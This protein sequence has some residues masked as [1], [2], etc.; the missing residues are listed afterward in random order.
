MTPATAPAVDALLKHV[1]A[2]NPMVS[3]ARVPGVSCSVSCCVGP[4]G[5]GTPGSERAFSIIRVTHFVEDSVL[6]ALILE[7]AFINSVLVGLGLLKP[8]FECVGRGRM[9]AVETVV[10]P[11]LLP[12]AWSLLLYAV[13]KGGSLS[14]REGGRV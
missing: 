12:S 14:N 13:A 3:V 4:S 8:E 1:L 2:H 6:L 9:R 7:Q 5:S 10:E 11:V